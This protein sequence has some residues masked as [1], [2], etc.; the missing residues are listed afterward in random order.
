MKNHTEVALF[1]SIDDLV[2]VQRD[3]ELLDA[4]RK[5]ENSLRE[6]LKDVSSSDLSNIDNILKDR[7][8][9]II[10]AVVVAFRGSTRRLCL[11]KKARY[12][13]LFLLIPSVCIFLLS[14]IL[15]VDPISIGP[16]VSDL[17]LTAGVFL[18]VMGKFISVEINDHRWCSCDRCRLVQLLT[19]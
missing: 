13:F 3:E 17:L 16:I 12:N 6:S 11:E 10:D 7:R 5:E 1:K 9:D 8:D 2:Q 14:L 19:H 18:F 4:F 15:R